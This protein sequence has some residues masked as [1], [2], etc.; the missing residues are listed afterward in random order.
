MSA[1]PTTMIVAVDVGNT[2]THLAAYQVEF[3]SGGA[4]SLLTRLGP[5][6]RWTDTW[7]VDELVD[8]HQSGRC[9]AIASVNSRRENEFSGWL[10]EHF[11]TESM[12]HIRGDQVGI[13]VNVGQPD[14]VG[15]DRLLAAAA[16]HSLPPFHVP[17]IVVDA[18]TAVTVDLI[19]ASGTFQGGTILAGRGAMTKALNEL[20]E[21]LP[22]LTDEQMKD[23]VS[24]VG[25]TTEEALASGLYWGMV[26][27]VRE[28]IQ[29]LTRTLDGPPVIMT[30]GGDARRLPIPGDWVPDLVLLGIARVGSRLF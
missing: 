3:S 16:A 1:E 8:G 15:I 18:G 25:K 28:V 11:P 17:K 22:D 21:K 6:C 4:P 9:W 27:G 13:P 12:Q 19:D 7:S 5:I 14:R 23:S 30:T 10:G 26:G 29:Q 20:A 24:A 2:S